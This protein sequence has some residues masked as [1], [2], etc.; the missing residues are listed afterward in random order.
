[1]E[2]YIRLLPGL[3]LAYLV[4]LVSGFISDAL[5]SVA[6]LEALTLSIFIGMLY[7]NI[8]GVGEKL[9]PGITYTLKKLLKAGIVLL[10][11][12]LSFTSVLS[13][14]SGMLAVV[15]IYV[16]LALLSAYLIGKMTGL[17]KDLSI[18]IGVGTSIC[19]ASAIVALAPVIDANDEDMV[20]SVAVVSLLGAVGV[21]IYSAVAMSSD[22]LTD[23]QYGA[24]S[25]LTLH[26]VAHAIAA[27]FAGG[28]PA[29]E[30]GTFVKMS[31]VIMMVP[32][33]ILLGFVSKKGGQRRVGL[34]V[35]VILFIAAGIINTIGVLP[36]TGVFILAKASSIL[37]MMAMTSMGLMVDFRAIINRG[38][39]ALVSGT[40]L[41]MALSVL[42]L[43]AV[44]MVI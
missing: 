38:K 14:G 24:W 33:S 15:A 39:S 43:L 41:F 31:R 42:G 4:T 8:F 12:K 29:G 28:K 16:P 9:R 19:G 27:A 35:Y 44:R 13:V 40:V 25:G 20:T 1:M 23:L 2:K 37:I 34:P 10:G 21:M 17:S 36:E 7:G 3:L 32:V 22:I 30:L 18:L 11:F 5:S 6:T 26:G